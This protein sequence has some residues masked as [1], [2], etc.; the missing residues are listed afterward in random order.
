MMPPLYGITSFQYMENLHSFFKLWSNIIHIMITKFPVSANLV[1][2]Y[3]HISSVS[4]VVQ[5]CPTLC[6]PM[7]CSM[8]GCPVH[9]YTIMHTS[10]AHIINFYLTHRLF[11]KSV[12]SNGI[13]CAI[14]YSSVKNKFSFSF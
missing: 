9:Y 8:P 13:I 3:R 10:H 12:K 6:D 7:N 4:S 11:E 14:L 2:Y 1:A 5:S